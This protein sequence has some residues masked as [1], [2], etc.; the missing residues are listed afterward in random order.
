MLVSSPTIQ[1]KC[2]YETQEPLYDTLT[3]RITVIVAEDELVH[4]QVKHFF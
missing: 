1:G 4:E 2:N 3:F